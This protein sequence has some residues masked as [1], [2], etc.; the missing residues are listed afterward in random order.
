MLFEQMPYIKANEPFDRGFK[1]CIAYKKVFDIN[2]L[3]KAKIKFN[4]L[5]FGKCV[6]NGIDIFPSKMISP[7]SNFYKTLWYL[8]IDISKY[9]QVGK[10]EIMFIL[11]GGYFNEAVDTV[12]KLNEQP[13]R[14]YQQLKAIIE[15][16]DGES[17][18]TDDSWEYTKNT[19]FVFSQTRCGEYY[20]SR[21]GYS[22]W[23]NVA[24]EEKLNLGK[25]R[26]FNCEPIV[27]KEEI[28][29]K[30]SWKLHDSC[31]V[32]DFGVNFAGYIRVEK[33]LELNQELVI[34]YAENLSGQDILNKCACEHY[35]DAVIQT[36]KLIGNGEL[37]KWSPTFNYHG[38]RYVKIASNQPFDITGITAIRLVQDISLNFKF[39]CSDEFLN[40][41]IE[42]Y[43]NSIYSNTFN[44]ITDCP[45]REKLGWFND[46]FGSAECLTYL[47]DVR[48]FY[49][50]YLQD[51]LDA[52]DEEGNFPCMLP[53]CEW[54]RNTWNGFPMSAILFE[55][56]YQYYKVYG[57]S[58]LLKKAF[59]YFNKVIDFELS[60]VNQNGLLFR[61]L[62][63]WV[64]P[65]ENIFA[66][67]TPSE[68]TTSAIFIYC[69]EICKE[70]AE[71]LNENSNKYSVLSDLIKLRIMDIYLDK[72]ERCVINAQ[73]AVAIMIHFGLYNDI[74][75]LKKQLKGLIEDKQFH[76]DCGTIGLKY[77]Y[78]ALSKCDLND[79]AY[80][81]ITASGFPSYRDWVDAGE[82]SLCENW[83]MTS[84]QNH[85]MFSTFIKFY[86]ESLMGIKITE[87]G[88]SKIEFNPFFPENLNYLSY[89][90]KT[91]NGI[92]YVNWNRENDKINLTV[93]KPKEIKFF[94]SLNKDL[95]NYMIEEY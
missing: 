13:F 82:T 2:E 47:F 74:L 69:L 40:K 64:G 14:D 56:P 70:T 11:N 16:E 12:W 84:S 23:N 1:G 15:F 4:I 36:D 39:N 42:M 44:M 72:E 3:K 24:V 20:D 21:L 19:P 7:L 63:D 49:K 73:T 81:I 26:K 32:L 85:H 10:N 71:I 9:L 93:K 89:E 87:S 52:V 76:H 30:N 80:K 67:P 90:L 31:F 27:E 54:G 83:W 34:E 65:Y 75:P 58:S 35:F 33:Q 5:G 78:S 92:I 86:I 55:I 94:T 45:T 88:F 28:N 51:I 38:F 43:V 41:L 61:G 79:Y 95:I 50:K 59:K 22:A 25:L 8:E 66:P 6:L 91:T 60:R 57:D 48:K 46:A 29:V 18:S 17:I 77:L 68:L 53:V 37:I 62:Y